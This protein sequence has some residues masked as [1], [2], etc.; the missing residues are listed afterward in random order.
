M[1]KNLLFAAMLLGA[2]SFSYAQV[3]TISPANATGEDPITITLDANAACV[4][5]GKS[6]VTA[7]GATGVFMH[8]GVGIVADVTDP[9]G[10][11]TNVI[12]WDEPG[13][14]LTAGATA[15]TYSITIT[16]RRFYNVPAGE[17]IYRLSMVFNGG[18][19]DFEAKDPTAVPG[20]CADFFVELSTATSVNEKA[21]EAVSVK[22]YP[23]PFSASTTVSFTTLKQANVKVTAV[24]ILGQEVATIANKQMEEGKHFIVWNGES[25]NGQQLPNGQYF[26]QVSVDGAVSTSKVVLNR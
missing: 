20:E 8:S 17:T 4:P 5:T 21:I 15:G 22:T 12:N 16:Q 13:T 10:A 23:N 26:I 25:T 1:K 7:A 14:Q 19:W 18:S 3:V 24:N 2:S 11:W 6:A 9:D